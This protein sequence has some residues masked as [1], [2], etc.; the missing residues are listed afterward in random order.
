MKAQEVSAAVAEIASD[1]RAGASDPDGQYLAARDNANLAA[2]ESELESR[3]A[4]QPAQG[5]P[6]EQQK[7]ETAGFWENQGLGALHTMESMGHGFLRSTQGFWDL[8]DQAATLVS[9][10]TGWE[11]GG[12]FKHLFEMAEPP[13]G[14][15]PETLAQKIVSG[16]AAAPVEIATIS[17]LPGSAPVTMAYMGAI[18]GSKHGLK[19]AALEAAQGVAMGYALEAAGALRPGV[20]IPAMAALGGAQAKAGGGGPEEI[21]Q[22]AAVMGGLGIMGGGVDK[23]KEFKQR[24]REILQVKRMEEGQAEFQGQM[25]VAGY[26]TEILH[27]QGRDRARYAVVELSDLQP[28][29][30]AGEGFKKNPA[31]PEKTQERQYET[32]KA[33]QAKVIRN[34]RTYNPAYTINTDPSMINGPPAVTREGVVLGGNSRIMSLDEVYRNHPDKAALYRDTLEANAADFGLTPE[35]ISGFSQPVLVRVVDSSVKTPADFQRRVRLYNEPPTQAMEAKVEGVSKARLMSDESFRI[36]SAGL[37]E[38]G[39]T[40]RQYMD[41]PGSRDFIAS[42]LRDG[43]LD[44]AQVNR[45]IAPKT[46]LLTEDGK[47]LVEQ[48]VRGRVF[49]DP[50]VLNQAPAEAVKKLDLSL[51]ALAQLKARGDDWDIIPKLSDALQ[52][53]SRMKAQGFTSPDDYFAQGDMFQKDKASA[54]PET[55]ALL[56]AIA[57]KKPTELRTDFEDLARAATADVP[58]QAAFAFDTPEPPQAAFAR[59][60]Q[61]DRQGEQALAADETAAYGEPKQIQL[62]LPEQKRLE[63]NRLTGKKT[64]A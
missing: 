62:P 40:L 41:K 14:W 38:H 39:G 1:L 49:D 26:D 36:L 22:G 55:R 47:R 12:V 61:P 15:T 35:E 29:H 32:D 46:G 13:E 44:Q 30:L 45:M 57:Q 50:E 48:V 5:Q 24:Q 52:A 23:A 7:K 31:Y 17:A 42:L 64:A 9:K 6:F 2:I 33:E 27:N 28:S 18:R 51:P 20:R 21:A 53:Y 60:F 63:D 4:A 34:A 54:D 56:H 10:A 58:A 25:P 19:G 3:F 43:V 8:L 16:L 11:K 37:E 59:I